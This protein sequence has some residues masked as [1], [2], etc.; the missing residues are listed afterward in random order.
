MVRMGPDEMCLCVVYLEGGMV[1]LGTE[2]T[3]LCVVNLKGG[4]LRLR[5]EETCL[6]V[7]NLDV[8]RWDWGQ[9]KCVYVWYI[10]RVE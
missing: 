5:P 7:V 4:I 3:C 1:A 2:E 8:G 9:T 6:C 10:Y